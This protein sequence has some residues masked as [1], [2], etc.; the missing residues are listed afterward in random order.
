VR[1]L[2]G[3]A[4]VA[5]LGLTAC[6]E[7]PRHAGCDGD[8]LTFCFVGAENEPQEGSLPCEAPMTA[9]VE[10]GDDDAKCVYGP[11]EPCNEA[12]VDRC[13]GALRVWCDPRVGYAQAT[14]CSTIATAS[15]CG[16]DPETGAA[17][18]LP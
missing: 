1:K 13:E 3:I 17:A 4:A 6:G 18:C 11:A 9:C 16:A 8:R 14:D 12:F 15:R 10:L 5:L 7:C 2:C